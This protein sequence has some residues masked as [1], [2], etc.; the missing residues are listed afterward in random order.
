MLPRRGASDVDDAP[1]PACES[2]SEYDDDNECRDV[3]IMWA[4]FLLI[5]C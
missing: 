3:L 2:K 4:L 5:G 1:A